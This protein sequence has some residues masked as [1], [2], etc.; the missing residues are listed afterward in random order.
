MKDLIKEVTGRDASY[1]VDEYQEEFINE[2]ELVKKIKETL[3]KDEFELLLRMTY[4]E[5]WEL[6]R[7]VK[8][9]R[10]KNE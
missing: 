2:Y 6:Y 9:W 3:S 1:Y 5:E 8:Y 10:D 7:L 4:E